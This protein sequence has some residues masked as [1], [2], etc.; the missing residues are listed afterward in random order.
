MSEEN[1]MEMPE[2]L[3]AEWAGDQVLQLFKD[4]SAGASVEHVQLKTEELDGSVSL[5]QAESAFRVGAAK[6]IQIRYRF[7]GDVWS[8]TILPEGATTTIIRT[9][10]NHLPG[11]G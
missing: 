6:A 8:D 1:N 5:E 4:L 11:F 2:I 7:D 9:R 3:K 10:M